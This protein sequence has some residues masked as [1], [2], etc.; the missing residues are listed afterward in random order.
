MTLCPMRPCHQC[1][2]WFE[3]PDL[4]LQIKPVGFSHIRGIRDYHVHAPVQLHL[5]QRRQHVPFQPRDAI[6]QRMTESILPSNLQRGTR[7]I[8]CDHANTGSETSNRHSNAP[9]S[10][11][12]IDKSSLLRWRNTPNHFLNKQLRLWPRNKHG[13]CDRT[14][15][16]AKFLR[17]KNVLEWFAREAPSDKSLHP[18]DFACGERPVALDDLLHARETEH[19]LDQPDRF[20]LARLN[21]SR[22]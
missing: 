5:F 16:P 22:R 9:G 2:S 1:L 10:G 14:F 15:H 20:L 4:R 17:P 3:I 21:P 19:K 11:A 13:R 8:D 12:D 6:T 7:N 18:G